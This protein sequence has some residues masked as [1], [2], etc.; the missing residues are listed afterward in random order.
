MQVALRM[1]VAEVLTCKDWQEP[2]KKVEGLMRDMA[3]LGHTP[4][5]VCFPPDAAWTVVAGRGAPKKHPH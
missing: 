5:V 4:V 2:T 3:K 1:G